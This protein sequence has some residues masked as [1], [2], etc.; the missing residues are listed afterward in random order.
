MV[1]LLTHIYAYLGLNK[2]TNENKILVNI[3]QGASLTKKKMG[4]LPCEVPVKSHQEIWGELAC[5]WTQLP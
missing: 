3:R 4:E 1:N 5:D 2:L